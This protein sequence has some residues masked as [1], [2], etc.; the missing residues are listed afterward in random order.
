MIRKQRVGLGGAASERRGYLFLF[1]AYKFMGICSAVS[2]C[3]LAENP[4]WK[5]RLCIVND[6]VVSKPIYPLVS[7]NL[8]L[9]YFTLFFY[10]C[11][12]KNNCSVLFSPSTAMKSITVN[13]PNKINHTSC[14][15]TSS[16]QI[17]I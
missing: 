3:I 14:G 12:T 13:F 10:P 16:T 11:T 9:L 6:N 1:C 4:I 2:I 17:T 15:I 7:Y 8:L 5:Q